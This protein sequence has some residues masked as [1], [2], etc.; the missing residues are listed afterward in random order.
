MHTFNITVTKGRLF[1]F[2]CT[3]SLLVQ[4][5]CLNSFVCI[6][7]SLFQMLWRRLG[8]WYCWHLVPGLSPKL[9]IVFHFQ[10]IS[11]L[12]AVIRIQDFYVTIF[13]FKNYA[14]ILYFVLEQSLKISIDWGW[15]PVSYPNDFP[16]RVNSQKLHMHQIWYVCSNWL[17]L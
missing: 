2:P 17:L 1:F 14:T 3:G 6:A 8:R 11:S 7:S 4:L 5:V 13:S 9:V 15:H 16:I 10:A 12:V